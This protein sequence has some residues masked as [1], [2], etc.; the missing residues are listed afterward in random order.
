MCFYL[1]FVL[2]NRVSQDT[3][4]KLY[5]NLLKFENPVGQIVHLLMVQTKAE[6]CE[7]NLPDNYDV[8]SPDFINPVYLDSTNGFPSLN[9]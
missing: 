7:S 8:I 6:Q 2:S 5:S 9:S 4:K 3:A 1:S